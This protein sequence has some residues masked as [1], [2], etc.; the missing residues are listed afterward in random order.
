[1]KN[2]W[3]LVPIAV[4]EVSTPPPVASLH[5]GSGQSEEIIGQLKLISTRVP[6]SSEIDTSSTCSWHPTH[7]SA[8]QQ[9]VLRQRH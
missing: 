8:G 7:V 2:T 9:S 1:L 3:G 4:L 5:V 6:I